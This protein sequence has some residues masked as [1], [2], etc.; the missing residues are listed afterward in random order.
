M[1]NIFKK[2]FVVLSVALLSGVLISPLI[3]NGGSG[4]DCDD[5]AVIYC[6]TLTTTELNNKIRNGTGR[7]N[8]SATQLTALYNKFGYNVADYGKLKEGYVTKSNT[9]VLNGKTIA[10]NVYSMGRHWTS[11]STQVSG[12]SYPLYLRHPAQS[13]ISNSIPAFIYLNTD[14]SFRMAIIKSCGN[15]VP[16]KILA[17]APTYRLYALKFIDANGNGHWD[18]NEN[19]R[20]QGVTF[21]LT[22]N[23]VNKTA[24][25]DSMGYAWFYGMA[26]GTYTIAES[27][28]SGYRVTT[29]NPQ[30]LVASG[31][32]GAR[33]GRVFGNQ[34][35][36]PAAYTLTVQKFNDVN[37]NGTREISSE[38]LLPNW[39]FRVT[40]NGIDRTITTNSS[41]IATLS[42]LTAGSYTVREIEQS[43]WR[44]T[45]SGTVNVNVAGNTTVV[46]GNQRIPLRYSLNVQKF[47][48]VNGNGS[49]ENLTEPL[50]SGWQFRVTGNNVDQTITTNTSGVATLSNLLAG[51]YTVREIEQSGWR[52]TTSGTVDVRL[53]GDTTVVFG[54]QRIPLKSNLQVYKFEDANNNRIQDN[55]EQN[56]AGWQFIV[57]GPNFRETL[58]T[59]SNGFA[60]LTDLEPGEYTV[61]EV[62]RD[63]WINT[64]GIT[65]S[66]EIEEGETE[67]TVFG[68]QRITTP[69]ITPPV[70]PPSGG[71]T[72]PVSGPIET[73]GAAGASMTL[74]GGLLAWIRSKKN[75]LGALKK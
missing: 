31:A 8:Q 55:G 44:I 43:G 33:I 27:V 28:P 38:A 54:N 19:Q 63:D 48:D 3:V 51:T 68:N 49:R 64:T 37:G 59:D 39:Q 71:E 34:R 23:G 2:M 50:I 53:S 67:V 36:L 9:V 15:I 18:S 66:R 21:R 5:N 10:S 6:G 25:T 13:F 70:T 65:L 58:T 56:L 73:A 74:S 35:I 24:V 7:T 20:H 40:G 46:F 41:G 29:Q 30:T 4:R 72:L 11:G 17:P 12:I 47:N 22:G 14:G 62:L 26:G 32:A 61:T 42:N 75:L 57:T 45:T 60:E 16:G 69:P 1:K 52:I